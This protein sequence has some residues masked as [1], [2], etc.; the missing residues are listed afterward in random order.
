MH[1]CI[2]LGVDAP[3][4]AVDRWRHAVTS[5][6]AATASLAC[7]SR[8]RVGFEHQV[9]RTG[10]P[11]SS[12]AVVAVFLGRSCWAARR[13]EGVHASACSLTAASRPARSTSGLIGGELLDDVL[14]S[15]EVRCRP[16]AEAETER[17][18]AET[19]RAAGA[20]C[21]G[22]ARLGRGQQASCSSAASIGV[23]APLRAARRHRRV[24]PRVTCGDGAA[25]KSTCP[26]RPS[27]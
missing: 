3:G 2:L 25:P 1:L 6:F 24:F 26:T 10:L 27:A 23:R 17:A 5:A 16:R 8:Q 20:A 13:V 11:C 14:L 21:A 22:R 15:G 7:R 4:K 9:A 19:E 18:E 12:S